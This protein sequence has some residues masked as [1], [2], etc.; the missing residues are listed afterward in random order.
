MPGKGLEEVV[1]H[2][3][4]IP[5]RP[6]VQRSAH[7]PVQ[8]GGTGKAIV[9]G[10]KLLENIIIHEGFHVDVFLVGVAPQHHIGGVEAALDFADVA[11][12]VV[13]H[14][15][16]E[17][18]GVG[19]EDLEAGFGVFA[20]F[21]LMGVPGVIVQNRKIVL[22]IIQQEKIAC[23]AAPL[24]ILA[25]PDPVI[26]LLDRLHQH[27]DALVFPV[28][29]HLAKPH[30]GSVAHDLGGY[31]HPHVIAQQ[32][33]VQVGTVQGPVV[34][35]V[36]AQ[37]RKVEVL[38]RRL[39]GHELDAVVLLVKASGA[40]APDAEQRRGRLVGR[41]GGVMPYAL[42]L[43]RLQRNDDFRLALRRRGIANHGIGFVPDDVAGDF[44]AAGGDPDDGQVGAQFRPV[45][46]A[47]LPRDFGAEMLMVTGG[48]RL[49]LQRG[50]RQ[51]AADHQYQRG[52]AQ[53]LVF[54]APSPSLGPVSR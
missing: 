23:P 47:G 53:R 39:V 48:P 43:D 7:I 29:N 16:G 18:I 38:G 2:V 20:K 42:P 50:Y 19:V 12:D 9:V 17:V 31:V 1:Q 11:R 44:L 32:R 6:D 5:Y 4:I 24:L 15:P 13:G 36:H 54:H 52:H 33:L 26:A 30:V 35:R 45:A 10:Q 25:E 40:V 27:I 49:P 21:Q 41:I 34:V 22:R 14:L 46:G 51:R 8:V 3:V 37:Q 28:Q